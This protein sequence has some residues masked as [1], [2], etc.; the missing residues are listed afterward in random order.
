MINRGDIYEDQP[1]YLPAKYGLR[2]TRINPTNEA[3]LDMQITGRT[4]DIFQHPPLLTFNLRDGEAF[5]LGKAKLH[6]PIIVL[7]G[8]G[9]DLLA[10]PDRA[11]AAR[12][13]LCAP[14]YGGDQFSEALRKRVR[15]YEFPNLFYLPESKVPVFQE[16]FVRFDEMQAISRHHLRRRRPA[17][18]SADAMTAFEEWL[19]FFLTGRL[20]KDSLLALYRQEELPKTV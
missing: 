14:I 3:D 13:Y 12:A 11:T 10:G 7:A 8:E 5:V 15:A 4:E 6:R 1:M 17:R 18:L 9:V 19:Y 16:G 2:L 20:Q